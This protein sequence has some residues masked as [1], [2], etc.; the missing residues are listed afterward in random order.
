MPADR[1]HELENINKSP[2]FAAK[3]FVGKRASKNAVGVKLVTERL[4]KLGELAPDKKPIEF[5]RALVIK[6]GDR[7]PTA[8][9]GIP[10]IGANAQGL[11]NQSY[12]DGWCQSS[13][14]HVNDYGAAWGECWDNSGPAKVLVSGIAV[15]SLTTGVKAFTLDEFTPKELD[16]LA[17]FNVGR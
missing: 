8:F 16:A 3:L 13:W 2:V 4:R 15:N 17:R 1:K 5:A 12:L 7:V 11:A 14:Q 6:Q 9:R 10:G